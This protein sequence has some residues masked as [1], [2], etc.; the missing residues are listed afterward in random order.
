MLLRN[1]YITFSQIDLY[2][3]LNTIEIMQTNTQ[4]NG[5]ESFKT[6]D[7]FHSTNTS[8][9]VWDTQASFFNAAQIPQVAQLI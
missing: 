8:L 9:G 4:T 1:I 5:K 2:N 7:L 6:C 3:M